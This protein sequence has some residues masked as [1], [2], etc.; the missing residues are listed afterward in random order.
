MSSNTLV[1]CPCGEYHPFGFVCEKA[2]HAEKRIADEHEHTHHN[3]EH[4]GACCGHGHDHARKDCCGHEQA[5][6]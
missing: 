4:E 2:Q 6:P 1:L 5:A 3:H